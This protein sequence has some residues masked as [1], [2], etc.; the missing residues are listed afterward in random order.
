PTTIEL[1]IDGMTCASC[2][3]RVERSL[4]EVAGVR[5]SV[6]YALETA[7]VEAPA[8]TDVTALV[9]VVEAAGYSA[10]PRRP[11]TEPADAAP[12]LGRRVA[13]VAALA[14]P[15]IALG[16]VPALQFDGWEWL[17][18]ALATPIATWGA[19]PFHRAAPVNAGGRL[20]LRAP[21][22]G[23]NA[24]PAR[25]ARLGAHA[26][27][28]KA[29]VQRLADRVA[30]VFVPAV[31]VLAAATFVGWLA[32]GAGGAGALEPAVAVLI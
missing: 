12:P 28:G 20:V 16:M 22:V 25:L 8:G 17:S 24:T 13:V 26:Q 23:P 7:R 19:W 11:A 5:A 21:R 18:L 2:A 29:P 32:A 27:S 15:V 1:D 3:A 6:N 31:L 30:A 10:R 9:R 4:N 14:V